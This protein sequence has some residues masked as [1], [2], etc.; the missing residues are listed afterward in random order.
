MSIYNNDQIWS[1]SF[2]NMIK[3]QLSTYS[4]EHNSIDLL[5]VPKNKLGV[6]H[7]ISNKSCASNNK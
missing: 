4:H 1:N 7:I 3:K 2:S 5:P 6:H